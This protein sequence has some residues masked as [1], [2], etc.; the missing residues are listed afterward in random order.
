MW[1]NPNVFFQKAMLQATAGDSK[2]E[3]GGLDQKAEALP[4]ENAGCKLK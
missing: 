1:G 2:G 3:S 4:A